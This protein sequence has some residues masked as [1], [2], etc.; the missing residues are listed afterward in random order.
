VEPGSKGTVKV[1]FNPKGFSGKFSKSIYVKSNATDDV[2]ILKI[3]GEVT[4]KEKS[5]FDIFK[6][7]EGS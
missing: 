1:N 2:V 4:D 3:E 5:I 6:R 7:K